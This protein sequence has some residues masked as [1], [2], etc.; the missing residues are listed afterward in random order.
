MVLEEAV[1]L[2]YV[3]LL[4][5]E[6]MNEWMNTTP[7]I[8]IHAALTKISSLSKFSS[9]FPLHFP[10]VCDRKLESRA[11]S[12]DLEDCG[13]DLDLELTYILAYLLVSLRKQ[14]VQLL[15]QV[16]HSRPGVGRCVIV[17]AAIY[18]RHAPTP[19]IS[20]ATRNRKNEPW[21]EREGVVNTNVVGI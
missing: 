12:R 11:V 17:S 2:S 1:D 8:L 6:W 10:G 18:L 7:R 4:M 13:R 5:N 21:F 20:D 16:V 14:S 19:L 9:T 15:S 3:R